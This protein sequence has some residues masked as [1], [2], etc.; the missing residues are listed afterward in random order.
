[1]VSAGGAP[2]VATHDGA[3]AAPRGTLALV[4]DLA[5]AAAGRVLDAARVA[6][7]GRE[8]GL[9]AAVRSVVAGVRGGSAAGDATPPSPA[10][11]GS[12][13][14]PARPPPAGAADDPPPPGDP[15]PVWRAALADGPRRATT[16]TLAPSR[17]LAAAADALGRVALLDV[18]AGT[19]IG[20][21]K[22]YRGAQLAWLPRGAAPVARPPPRTP[23]RRAAAAARKRKSPDPGRSDGPP[24][25]SCNECPLLA[26]YA[27]RRGAV[28]VWI[29]SPPPGQRV[30]AL[31]A[32]GRGRL[33]APAPVLG[34]GGGGAARDAWWLDCETGEAWERGCEGGGAGWVDGSGSVWS[35]TKRNTPNSAF[36]PSARASPPPPSI[37]THTHSPRLHH[38]PASN[39]RYFTMR[40]SAAPSAARA[41]GPMPPSLPS[42]V[43]ASD[44]SARPQDAENVPP[45]AVAGAGG[46]AEATPAPAAAPVAAPKRAFVAPAAAPSKRRAFD[47]P[48]VV[49]GG[50]GVA[51][52]KALGARVQPTV[53][54]PQP[55]TTA[56]NFTSYYAV[57]YAKR[58]NKKRINKSF[59]DGFLEVRGDSGITLYDAE[60]K[61]IA[62]SRL[63]GMADAPEGATGELGGW[64]FEVG[65]RVSPGAWKSGS[66]FLAAADSAPVAAAARGGGGVPPSRLGFKAV[67]LGSDA[68]PPPPPLRPL[69][70]PTAPGAVV[71]NADAVAARRDTVAVVLDPFLARRLRPHQVHAVRFMWDRVTSP[72]SGGR[73]GGVLADEMGLGKTLSTIAL[74][75]CALKQGSSGRP[76]ARRA[77]VACPASL[78]GNWASEIKKWCGDERLKCVA[79]RPGGDADAG[80]AKWKVTAQFP[81]LIASYEAVRKLAPAM[82]GCVD[83]LVCDEAHR[84]KS[85]AGSATQTALGSLRAPRVLLLTGTPLQNN[86]GEL[87]ATLDFVA[88]GVLGPLATF[89]RVFAIPIAASRDAAA[90]PDERALGATRAAE[91]AARIS[92]IVLRR[93]S[94]VLAASLP[95]LH[96]VDVFCGAAA[97]AAGGLQGRPGCE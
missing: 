56:P 68:A 81:I 21:W 51:V 10:R 18:G 9:R 76:I 85:A 87:W 77:V 86:L 37:P 83:I 1:M 12:A 67:G 61:Q 60:N 40:R 3:E 16:L 70:D 27:P 28:E 44:A 54:P 2:A 78:V 36:C 39:H 15:A 41:S 33:L 13:L 6:V 49:G 92:S 23:P 42:L 20:L 73:A 79:I 31:P 50:G 29:P 91:L 55:S 71:V 64:E 14:S 75:F 58:S 32:G 65:E 62:R 53:A 24:P 5:A 17:G 45:Q 94:A 8:G 35:E 4:A 82:E 84:L 74:I 47:A 52:V 25:S 66:V 38:S 96:V 22:G 48:G 89:Q 90:T 26:V 88:P 19:V 97:G 72:P 7:V 80:V 34:A 69:H 57:L 30:A 93:T 46:A 63:K 59:M 43:A 95:P 11:P